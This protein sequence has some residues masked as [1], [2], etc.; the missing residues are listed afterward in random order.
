[1]ETSAEKSLEYDSSVDK[2]KEESEN[3]MPLNKKTKL[4][5]LYRPPTHDELQAL[6][7]TESLYRTNLIKLQ[8]IQSFITSNVH[9]VDY[10][11]VI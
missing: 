1:M 10:R 4:S 9:I 3:S 2:I 8:V 7:E 6:K 11:N 5:G